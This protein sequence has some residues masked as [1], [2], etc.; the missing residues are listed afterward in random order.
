MVKIEF[1][2]WKVTSYTATDTTGVVIGTNRSNRHAI[3]HCGYLLVRGSASPYHLY[4]LEIGN[5]ANV[6]QFHMKGITTLTGSAN[7]VLNGRVYYESTTSQFAIA[8]LVS[9]EI[10]QTEH[11]YSSTSAYGGYVHLHYPI[12]GLPATLLQVYLASNGGETSTFLHP[13]HYLATINNLGE[14]VT[15]TADKTMKITYLIEEQ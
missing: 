9:N 2:T 5:W 6:E 7:F 13:A 1:G 12:I 8:N 15:K 4:K 10:M 11:N 3:A 14:T